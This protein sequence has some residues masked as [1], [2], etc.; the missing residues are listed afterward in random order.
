MGRWDPIP[1]IWLEGRIYLEFLRLIRDP[2]FRGEDVPP[3]LRKPV[4]LIPGFL[5]GDWTLRTQYDWLSR[6]GYKPRLAGVSFNVMYSE[7]MLRPLLDTL[8]QM[9]RKTA[10][11]VYPLGQSRGGA[12]A[13][14]LSRRKPAPV[15]LVI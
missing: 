4:L 11:R 7:V 12:L 9:H 10:G 6:V 5:A 13:T 14:V 3:G 2:V 1:P 15:A 8:R